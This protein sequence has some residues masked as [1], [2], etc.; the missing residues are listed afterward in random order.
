MIFPINGAANAFLA[1]LAFLPISI[2][3]FIALSILF[4]FIPRLIRFLMEL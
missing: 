1:I 3:A 4:M 2:S